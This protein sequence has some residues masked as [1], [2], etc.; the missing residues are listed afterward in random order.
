MGCSDIVTT[1]PGKKSNVKPQTG[2]RS[3]AYESFT[4]PIANGDK[5]GFD[6]HIYFNQ[7]RLLHVE[8]MRDC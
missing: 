1:V 8:H 4:N 6:I 2:M 5:N 3:K 7:V